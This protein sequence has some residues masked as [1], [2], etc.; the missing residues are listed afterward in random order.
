VLALALLVGIGL[1]LLA[2]SLPLDNF[3]TRL[4]PGAAIEDIQLQEAIPELESGTHVVILN[5]VLLE[6]C[7]DLPESLY[8]Y[9]DS[10]PDTRFWYLLPSDVL[11]REGVSWLCLFGAEVVEVPRAVVRPLYRTLPRSFKSVDGEVTRT[12]E[13]L[14]SE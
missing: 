6:A 13:G 10:T 2:P 9:A 11:S 1:P 12:W 3:A 14:P 8:G 4:K 7:Q 5:D